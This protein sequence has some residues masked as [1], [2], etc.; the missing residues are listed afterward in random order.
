MDFL[1]Q[2]AYKNDTVTEAFDKYDE[3]NYSEQY[4]RSSTPNEL[5]TD[6]SNALT[7]SQTTLCKKCL[8]RPFS[9]VLI[10]CGHLCCEECWDE[11]QYGNK[12]RPKKKKKIKCLLP[13]CAAVII[14][15]QQI[16]VD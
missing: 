16:S 13:S 11:Q 7:Q 14:S 10:P 12:P 6:E 9:I 5:Q 1:R 3:P 15:A 2:L 8:T 4:S